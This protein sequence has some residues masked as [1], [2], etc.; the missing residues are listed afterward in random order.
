MEPLGTITKYYPFIDEETKSILNSLMAESSSY[1]DFVQRLCDVVIENEVPVNLVY[2]AAVQAWWGKTEETMKLIQEKYKD[3]LWIKPWAYYLGSMVRDQALYHDAVVEAITKAVNSSRKDW[4]ETELHLLH[5]FFHWPMG[6]ITS[7]FEPLEKAKKLIDANPLLNCFEPLI[8]AFEGM[9]KA[10]EGDIKDSLVVLRRGKDLAEVHD[11][12]L[13]KY[14]NMLQEGIILTTVNV[15]D[16]QAVFEDLYD[17]VQDLEAPYYVCEVL[18]DSSIAYEAAGEFDLS[19]SCQHEVLKTCDGIRPSDTLW[20]LISRTYATLGDGHQALEWINKGFEYSGLSE[21]P[22]M[23]NMKAWALALLNRIDE[24]ERILEAAHSLIIKFGAERLLGDYYHV[25]GVVEL[26]RGDFLAALDLIENAWD[27]AERNPRGTNQN[28]AL[29]DLARTEILID[30]Q[31]I[32]SPNVVVPGKWL[33]K[34]ENF[35]IERDLPG[36]RMQAALLKSEFYQNHG[37]LKDAHAT[38]V[39]ALTIT[40]SLGVVT[41]RKNITDRIRELNQL[42]REAEMSSEKRKW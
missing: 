23:H 20:M 40:D 18:N 32:D 9:A 10:R 37:Q 8:Y 2:L 33:S 3:L 17:L 30:K 22:T 39:D 6:D 16:A 5:A 42:L 13:Y 1:Y 26:R 4:I 15:Q 24:A 25:S 29:L 12:S 36:I 31:S 11:D 38:L 21:S 14:M 34:L 7:L 28:R 27:I 19:I 41:L 35:A